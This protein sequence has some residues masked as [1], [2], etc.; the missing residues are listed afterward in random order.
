MSKFYVVETAY[1]N[2]KIATGVSDTQ[3]LVNKFL[4]K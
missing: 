2:I 1:K 3:T 4:N